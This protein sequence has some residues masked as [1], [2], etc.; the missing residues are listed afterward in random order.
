MQAHPLYDDEALVAEVTRA[1][2]RAG[3][4][5][6]QLWITQP[7]EEKHAAWVLDV[8]A[9]PHKGRVLSLGS[10]IGGMEAAWAYARPDLQFTLVNRSRAQL[11]LTIG[12]GVRVCADA[13]AY[14]PDQFDGIPP[15]VIVMA[16]MLGHVL[17]PTLLKQAIDMLPP[18]G[19]ALVLDIFDAED[20][21]QPLL[22]Y[23]APRSV[24]M[25]AAGF[26]R[27]HVPQWHMHGPVDDMELFTRR[28]VER[29]K[30]AMWVYRA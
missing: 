8:V 29:T 1:H 17:A 5:M 20:A 3:L 4:T 9:P 7:T 21:V 6:L 11:D 26:T 14:Q 27:E 19:V 18:G 12:P 24:D 10:G 2:A 25:E 30:P 22:H 13:M 15:D 16:Y 23:D 28:V